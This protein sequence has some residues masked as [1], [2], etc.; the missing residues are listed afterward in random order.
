MDIGIPITTDLISKPL[1][2]SRPISSLDFPLELGI[3]ETA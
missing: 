2:G 3:L 1:K